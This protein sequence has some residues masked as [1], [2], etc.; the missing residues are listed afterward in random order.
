MASIG[1]RAARVACIA[2]GSLLIPAPAA[3][4]S[5]D[6]FLKIEGVDGESKDDKHKGEIEILSYSWGATRTG[7]ADALTD[8]LMIIRYNTEPAGA[9]A[10]KNI[11]LKGSKIG[12][13][14]PATSG[15]VRVAAGDVDGDG[16]AAVVSPRDPASGLAT[17]KRMHK[18]VT[19]PTPRDR[20]SLTVRGKFPGCAVGTRYPVLALSGA[21]QRFTLQD[22]II[23]SCSSVPGQAAPMEEVSFNYAKLKL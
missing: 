7:Q 21:G 18:P 12:E 2:L 14:A 1:S 6:Y 16:R 8:G 13:N 22:A 11:V 15:G 17:G 5:A 20:G 4:A 19:F 10:D 9:A 3:A 23:T